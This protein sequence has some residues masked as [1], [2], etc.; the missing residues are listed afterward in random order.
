MF[1]V[2]AVEVPLVVDAA[3]L[4]VAINHLETISNGIRR[5]DQPLDQQWRLI[6]EIHEMY[7]GVSLA[8]VGVLPRYD[9]W[10]AG[11]T[12]FSSSSIGW[13]GQ[14]SSSS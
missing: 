7:P 11:Q 12:V 1:L 10:E 5:Q 6:Q 8:L 13:A 3:V 4:P 14:I 2:L 9:W